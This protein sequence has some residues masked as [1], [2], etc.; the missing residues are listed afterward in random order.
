MGRFFHRLW[1]LTFIQFDY[2]SVGALF[3]A[4]CNILFP[5]EGLLW[6]LFR[7]PKIHGGGAAVGVSF[8]SEFGVGSV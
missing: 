8:A 3:G 1:S 4:D 5:F 7:L 6:L 2:C